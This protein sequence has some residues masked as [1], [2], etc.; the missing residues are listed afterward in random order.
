MHDS[1]A[2]IVR[3]GEVLFAV[4]EERLSRAKHDA[5][6]PRLAIKACLAAAGAKPEQLDAVCTGWQKPGKPFLH[7]LKCFVAGDHP[8]SYLAVLN[9]ARH[10]ASMWHQGGGAN[11]FTREFG[12]TKARFHYVAHPSRTPSA[13]TLS[14]DSSAR[15]FW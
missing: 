1:S 7:D 8:V 11:P 4:A 3:D 10:F 12:P 5:R 14:R 9:S 2:C 15:P 6:F 13:P